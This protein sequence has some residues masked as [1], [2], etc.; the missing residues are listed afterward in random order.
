MSKKIIL[1][2]GGH[3]H[4]TVMSNCH[5][6]HEHGH[7]VTLITP[8]EHHYYSGMGPGML[9]GTYKPQ[10][11]RFNVKKMIED[12]HGHFI[13][14]SIIKV[15]PEQK[16]LV[17]KSGST[18]SYD[19][20]SF[21]VGSTVPHSPIEDMGENTFPVKPIINLLRARQEILKWPQ[22]KLIRILVI[23]GGA[24]GLEIA[25]NLQSLAARRKLKAEISLVAGSKLLRR[26][27]DK[28]S[29]IAKKSF[30]A[31]GIHVIEGAHVETMQAGEAVLDNGKKT[32][33]DFVFPASGV[34]PPP[35]FRDSGIPTDKEG[36][37]LVNHYLQST[38]YPEIFGGGDC[39][40]LQG[41]PLEKVGVYAVRENPVLYHNIMACA[42][43]NP[44]M[45]FDPGGKYLLIFNL[46]DG[47]GIYWRGGWVWDGRIAFLLK[48]YIDN[49]FM[50][51]FQLSGEREEL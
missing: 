19:V 10:E 17:L 50:K 47:T 41:H 35:L 28:V 8:S 4:M 36:G 43:G 24:A 42:E 2:G 38:A 46:G 25:G 3:A 12:R 34:K 11:I 13:K 45:N 26:F 32:A 44:L 9:S 1:A 30:M 21:N 5:V 51:K 27:P 6:F 23:G 31:R 22:D 48:D 7:T 16:E 37:M 49:R 20:L 14:D 39:I 33:F 15:D 29:T 18:I 40:S